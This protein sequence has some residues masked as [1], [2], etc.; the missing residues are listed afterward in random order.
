[1]SIIGQPKVPAGADLVRRLSKGRFLGFKAFVQR[2]VP[3]RGTKSCVFVSGVQR[4]GTNM[5][6]DMLEANLETDVFHEIDARAFANYELRPVAVLRGLV[7]NSKAR[8]VILKALLDG[9]RILDLLREFAPAKALWMV[10]SFYDCV[11][12]NLRQWPGGRNMID[13]LVANR[14]KAEWRGR[15]MTDETYGVVRDHYRPEMNNAS[16]Q[17][18]FWY[19]R[20]Q[21]FFDQN[22]D[23]DPRVLALSYEDTV[24]RPDVVL[25]RIGS[26]LGISVTPQ[27]ETIGHAAS[28]GKNARP[29]ID[30][31]IV[32]LCEV[33]QQRLKSVT[34]ST[35]SGAA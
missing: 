3:D 5:L 14:D 19:Y 12:S 21:L 22:L 28:I 9:D 10:R 8:V 4:S 29:D 34:D 31:R 27:M 32:G 24:H 7:D 23:R 20:N 11:N 1:M 17:A 15:G 16:A 33:M 26:F 35:L 6:M 30:E 2:V 18:L 25:K 13:D